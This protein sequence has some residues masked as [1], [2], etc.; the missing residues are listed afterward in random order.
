[1]DGAAVE[2]LAVAPAF[3]HIKQDCVAVPGAVTTD[4]VGIESGGVQGAGVAVNMVMKSGGNDFH[5]RS[6]FL[7]MGWPDMEEMAIFRDEVLPRVRARESAEQRQVGQR[8]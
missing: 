8:G 1:M 4:L 7:F 5:G 3:F 2:R 6:Q